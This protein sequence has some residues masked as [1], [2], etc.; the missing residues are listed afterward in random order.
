ML[1][2]KWLAQRFWR[3]TVGPG[4]EPPRTLPACTAFRF[5]LDA[6]RLT[7]VFAALAVFAWPTV[8]FP[9]PVPTVFAFEDFAVAFTAAAFVPV[10]VVV[11]FFTGAAGRVSTRAEASCVFSLSAGASVSRSASPAGAKCGI[12]LFVT[13]CHVCWD[14]IERCF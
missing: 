1:R 5:G 3:F 6:V 9:L 7:A 8:F 14:P 13:G 11:F 2:G 4:F 10:F 12:A